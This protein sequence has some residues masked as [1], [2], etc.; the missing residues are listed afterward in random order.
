MISDAQKRV[1]RHQAVQASGT[2][3]HFV[4]TECGTALHLPLSGSAVVSVKC[5][6]GCDL[7]ESAKDEWRAV[8]DATVAR[9]VE[10]VEAAKAR[11]LGQ[12]RGAEG[13]ADGN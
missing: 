2:T 12:G 10:A 6:C 13:Q 8:Q 1:E 7:E 5:P 9:N 3:R 11:G 4:C